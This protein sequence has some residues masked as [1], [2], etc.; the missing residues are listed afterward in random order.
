MYE[1]KLNLLTFLLK[2]DYIFVKMSLIKQ[3]LIIV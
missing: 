1:I 3:I 2:N